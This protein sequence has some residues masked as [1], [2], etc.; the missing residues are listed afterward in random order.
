[1]SE[2]VQGWFL[3]CVDRDTDAENL[4]MAAM[5]VETI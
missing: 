4:V 5:A 1:M 2:V 3:G